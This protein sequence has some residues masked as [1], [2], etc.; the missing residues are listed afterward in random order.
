MLFLS[1]P[2]LHGVPNGACIIIL[3]IC[4]FHTSA[5]RVSLK[6]VTMVFPDDFPDDLAGKN[7]QADVFNRG[8]VPPSF[9]FFGDFMIIEV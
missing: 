1:D 7:L 6:L 8:G 2:G 4:I 5:D 9:A 3:I